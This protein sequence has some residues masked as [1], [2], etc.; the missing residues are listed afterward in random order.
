MTDSDRQ[1]SSIGRQTSPPRL[2]VVIVTWN[3][4][5]YIRECLE[6]VKREATDAEVIV[7]DNNSADGT[8]G[9]VQREFPWV[10]LIRNSGNHGYARANN[11]GIEVSRGEYILLLNP[12]TEVNENAVEK[13]LEFAKSQGKGVGGVAPQLVNPDLTVQSS[14]RAFPTLR[15]LAWEFL[16]LS[17]LFPRSRTFGSWRMGYFDHAS[18]RE[19]DQ[20]MGSCLLVPAK[21]FDGVGLL[22]ERFP[23]F[24]NDVDLCYRMKK[25]GLP[26]VFFPG[27]SVIHHLGGS[28]RGV[29]PAMIASSHRSIYRYFRKHHPSAANAFLG[30]FLLLTAMVRVCLEWLKP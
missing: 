13:I 7:V 4:R 15:I 3:N 6:S 22:D 9:I 16:G 8:Q 19:V 28:T 25:A 1:A 11:Q 23:M 20:P 26:V 18:V 12:D 29:R 2:S 10:R 30:G 24:M 5:H 21:V 17:R 14:C 27:A